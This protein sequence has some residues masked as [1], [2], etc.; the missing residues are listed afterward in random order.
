M[1]VLRSS[2]QSVSPPPAGPVREYTSWIVGQPMCPPGSVQVNRP[3]KQTDAA[4]RRATRRRRGGRT[5][6]RF[7]SLFV[8]TWLLLQKTLLSTGIIHLSTYP[9]EEWLA[10]ARRRRNCRQPGRHGSTWNQCLIASVSSPG[11]LRRWSAACRIRRT[12]DR[13][14]ALASWMRRLSC[15]T[16]TRPQDRGRRTPRPPP[17]GRADQP[18]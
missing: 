12:P 6:L 10:S 18:V 1:Q 16:A 15:P 13:C 2:L 8:F 5:G 11:H 14:P 9:S 4:A 3:K 7:D 17:A